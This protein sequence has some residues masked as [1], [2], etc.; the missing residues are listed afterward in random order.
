MDP[1]AGNT[2]RTKSE[3]AADSIRSLILGGELTKKSNITY[4]S[5][6]ERLGMSQ[7]PIREAVRQ[8]EAE[9]LLR[10]IP[11]KGLSI[12]ELAD[13][14]IEEAQDIYLVRILLEREASRLAA[15]NITAAQRRQLREAR[16]AMEAAFAQ[17]APTEVRRLHVTWHSHVHR[18]SGSPYLATLCAAA[19]SRFPW[20]AVWIVPGRLQEA[21][22]QHRNIEE[23]ILD[24]EAEAAAQLMERHVESGRDAVIQH[25]HSTRRAEPKET[26]S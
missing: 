15:S 10:S 11:H 16:E 18:A 4:R 24:G 17:A 8:L 23:A 5:L 21:M 2:Y 9:G 26:H 22:E 6:A 13:L 12:T 20:E 7:T 25:L 19:W 3:V 1:D 14:S